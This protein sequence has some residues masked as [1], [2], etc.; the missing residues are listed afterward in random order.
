MDII[1]L[2]RSYTKMDVWGEYLNK[3][4]KLKPVNMP[5]RNAVFGPAIFWHD[6]T[7]PFS[8]IKDTL[9]NVPVVRRGSAS[10]ALM[11]EGAEANGIEPQGF[12]MSQHV[13]AARLNNLKS[14]GLKMPKQYFDLQNDK[15]LKRIDK[16]IEAMCCQALSGRVEYPL[17]LENGQ[18]DTFSINY[19]T[20]A[21]YQAAAGN[22]NLADPNT[23]L[24]DVFKMLQAMEQNIEDNG[25]G[26]SSLTYAGR[27]A[28]SHIM[29]KATSNNT[30]NIQVTIN[31][32]EITIG[33]YKV[34]RLSGKYDTIVGGRQAKVDKMPEDALCMVDLEAGHSFYY[35]AIDDLDAGLKAL[36]FFSK[37]V[38]VEDP[39]GATII[40]YSKP[41]PVVVVGAICWCNDAVA[42]VA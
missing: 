31:E 14:Q 17:K 20:P 27:V 5:V 11:D 29:D 30:R 1:D 2:F 8:E 34:V 25:Y 10:L 35:L 24:S 42:A 4:R 7:L 33:G 15:M 13:T 28:F 36:P 18:F 39:S 3:Y 32:N 41:V 23:K 40:G 21:V 6:V 9:T 12:V 16:G 37:T 19:G 26:G 22:I 38:K